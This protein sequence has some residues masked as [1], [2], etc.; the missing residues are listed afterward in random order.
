MFSIASATFLPFLVSF[1]NFI[2]PFFSNSTKANSSSVCKIFTAWLYVQS[3]SLARILP[4]LILTF[5]FKDTSIKAGFL[6]KKISKLS[7]ILNID[8]LMYISR[9]YLAFKSFGN[10]TFQKFIENLFDLNLSKI[11]FQNI[12]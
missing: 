3:T 8:I 12:Y 5:F 7:F 2:R 1:I 6:L 11:L 4:Y 9:K 10:S